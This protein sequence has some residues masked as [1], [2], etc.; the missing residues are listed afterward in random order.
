MKLLTPAV[1][2]SGQ[3]AQTDREI[4]R[5]QEVLKAS[6][7][8]RK[9]MANAE[10][11]FKQML[12]GQ[13]ARWMREEEEHSIKAKEMEAEIR[14]L[15]NRR[16]QAM[17]PVKFMQDEANKQFQI[18]QVATKLAQGR[19]EEAEAYQEALE[20]KL[21]AV[22]Q[23]E[24]DVIAKEKQLD[25]KESILQSQEE[26]TTKGTA[27][28]IQKLIEFENT[29]K[30]IEKDIDERKTAIR[31]R[32]LSQEARQDKLNR[33]EKELADWAKRLEDER[34]TLERAFARLSPNNKKK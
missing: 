8:A 4:I 7:K 17:I 25:V 15:E 6:D 24:Q 29:R 32:D 11:D 21:D 14:D 19:M 27:D 31:L 10:A 12:L 34:G 26:M 13:K 16:E 20:D 9:E 28:L 1:T 2:K 22:G 33:K 5:T 23:R 3:S 30:K 18:A